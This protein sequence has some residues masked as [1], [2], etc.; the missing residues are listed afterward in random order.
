MGCPNPFHSATMVS[1]MSVPAYG[2]PPQFS[3]HT[4]PSAPAIEAP[5]TMPVLTM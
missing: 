5:L 4:V 3:A 1:F 2:V